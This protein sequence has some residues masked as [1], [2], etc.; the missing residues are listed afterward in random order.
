LPSYHVYFDG[1]TPAADLSFAKQVVA[2][3][4]AVT[5]S[6]YQV[7]TIL[8]ETGVPCSLAGCG[9]VQLSESDRATFYGSLLQDTTINPQINALLFW[10]ME[11]VP[12]QYDSCATFGVLN[13]PAMTP[14][15][16]Q[17]TIWQYQ[18]QRP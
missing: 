16:T 12:V 18:Q 6:K 11:E 3:Y 10:T 8:G 9:E 5:P 1:T 7:Y 13:V 14:T 17:S 4:E 15:L 2:N